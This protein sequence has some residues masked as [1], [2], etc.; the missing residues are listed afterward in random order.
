MNAPKGRMFFFE[1]KNQKTFDYVEP[2]G[3]Q[4]EGSVGPFTDKSFFWFFFSKKNCLPSLS[5]LFNGL[6]DL[7]SYKL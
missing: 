4:E 1:K 3:A 6:T 5:L 7:R 2:T